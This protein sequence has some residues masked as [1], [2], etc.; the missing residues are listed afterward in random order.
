MSFLSSF[1]QG[2]Q[3]DEQSGTTASLK[4][5]KVE[6]TTFETGKMRD[7]ILPKVGVKL[8]GECTWRR[9]YK[10]MFEEVEWL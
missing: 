4:F 9:H 8:G 1:T 10:E 6:E 7:E 5:A 2:T 3:E